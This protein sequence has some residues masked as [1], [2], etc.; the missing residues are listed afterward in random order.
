MFGIILRGGACITLYMGL[1]K[2]HDGPHQIL[3]IDYIYLS[4]DLSELSNLKLR[5]LS[6]F[7]TQYNYWNG[8]CGGGGGGIKKC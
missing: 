5:P 2:Y 6:F 8:M 1:G 4:I 7:K 3:L